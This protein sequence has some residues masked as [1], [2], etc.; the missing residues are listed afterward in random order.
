MGLIRF[1]TSRK[2]AEKDI[3]T[4]FKP[5]ILDVD[6]VCMMH[7]QPSNTLALTH[8]RDHRISSLSDIP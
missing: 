4:N 3:S 8:P 7:S 6:L 5:E 1:Y 2:G